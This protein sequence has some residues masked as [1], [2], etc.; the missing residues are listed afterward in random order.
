MASSS[1]SRTIPQL[2]TNWTAGVKP[3][4]VP[5]QPGLPPRIPQAA[6]RHATPAGP[7]PF[8]DATITPEFGGI[9][10]QEQ[11]RLNALRSDPQDVVSEP[12]KAYPQSLFPN[13]TD[14]QQKM[15]GLLNLI[16]PA[17]PPKVP[18]TLYHV[19]GNRDGHFEESESWTI[20]HGDD[21]VL[22]KTLEVEDEQAHSEEHRINLIFIGNRYNIEPFFFTSFLNWIPSRYQE[23]LVDET[24]DHITLTITFPNSFDNN[25]LTRSNTI[26]T[27]TQEP[28]RRP[29]PLNPEDKDGLPTG[30]S[31]PLPQKRKVSRPGASPPPNI[32][33][34][35]PLPIS[36]SQKV[37][38]LDLLSLHMVR[39]PSGS[40]VISLHPPPEWKATTAEHFHSR[41]LTAGGSVYWQ[42]M[43]NKSSDPTLI[44]V[45]M[46]WYPLYAWD[47]ALEI[48]Y[49]HICWL[50]ARVLQTNDIHIT[51][52]LHVIRAFLLHYQ[53]LLEQFRTSVEFIVD[54]PN[55]VFHLDVERAKTLDPN[56]VT[57]R[58]TSKQ[59]LGKG[60]K[61]LEKN[62][63]MYN[64][65]MANVVD[66]TFNSLAFEEAHYSSDLAKASL[67]DSKI[68]KQISYITMVFFPASFVCSFFGMNVDVLIDRNGEGSA[69]F[70]AWWA[71]SIPLTVIT[72]WVVIAL[73]GASEDPLWM[74]LIW[75]FIHGHRLLRRF[76]TWIHEIKCDQMDNRRKKD[77]EKERLLTDL[78][79]LRLNQQQTYQSLR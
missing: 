51:R 1:S 76:S 78:E 57:R 56:E 60:I 63:G 22:W 23:N 68:V 71:S 39:R 40:T 35:A 52:Q 29:G 48:L 12:W 13:W 58:K 70:W 2:N 3:R 34:Q 31:R 37:I 16:V 28:F 5:Q 26:H 50:E 17:E 6:H 11:S 8:L 73:H 20:N 72:I 59:C 10:P 74:R 43:L 21:F 45:M 27:P 33:P 25:T 67:N 19:E 47:E 65:R 44:L 15:S 53:N 49:A 54:T 61:R 66:L 18:C 79:S 9:S 41:V 75:P 7:W 14:M 64:A 55:P 32:D 62:V 30:D 42:N 69:P 38:C 77:E 46:L 4:R 24:S 36:T